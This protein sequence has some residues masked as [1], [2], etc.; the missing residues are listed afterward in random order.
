MAKLDLPKSKAWVPAKTAIQTFR[1][2]G[3]K[4]TA[5]ALAELVDNAIEAEATSIQILSFEREQ[6]VLERTHR[7]IETLAVYDNGQGMPE[8]VLGLCLQFGMGT[9]LQSRKG[10]GRFGIGLPN[11]SVSQCRRVDVYSWQDGTCRH[12][13]LDIDEVAGGDSEERNPVHEIEMPKEYLDP[14]EGKPGESGTLVVWSRCD[15]LDLARTTTL[16]KRM[17]RHLCRVY[18][19]FLDDD[20]SYGTQRDLLLVTAGDGRRVDRLNANDPLYLTT[21]NTLPGHEEAATNVE[22]GSPVRVEVDCGPKGKD[23]SIVELHFSIAQPSTQS[24]G[25][26][27]AVGRHYAANTGIS[28]VRAGREIDFGDFGFF[29]AREERQR[30]WGCEVRFDPRLDELFGVTNN[31][32]S[33]RG[34]EYFDDKGFRTEHPD[35]WEEELQAS[36]RLQLMRTLTMHISK[37]LKE[38]MNTIT[39][40]GKGK[41]SGDSGDT[42]VD[43]STKLANALIKEVNPDSRSRKEGET[44]TEEE[45]LA[46]WAEQARTHEELSDAEVEEM[47]KE[48]VALEIAKEFSGWPGAQFFSTKTIGSTWTVILNQRHPFFVEMYEE[49]LQAEDSRYIQAL[50]LLLYAYAQMENELYGRVDDLEE[51]RETWGRYVRAFLKRLAENA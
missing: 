6:L 30:W 49:L 11:A 44:K 25:G 42:A 45:K 37:N 41:G 46:E 23:K 33:C 16:Y 20:D 7:R 15:R 14:I 1:D 32:Q 24:L 51:M 5:A 34:F 36:P 28:M 19:H 31:K 8:E 10:I 26:N 9:R 12:T 21:P 17:E 47:A 38:M 22:W 13:Y 35:D 50:D 4:N 39:S 29:N 2:S 48:H 18:R 3:Y 27:S 43:P 40:R